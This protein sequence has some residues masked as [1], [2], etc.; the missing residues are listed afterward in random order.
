MTYEEVYKNYLAVNA[1]AS[2]MVISEEER[3]ICVAK[4]RDAL[5]LPPNNA[6]SGLVPAI[7]SD[8]NTSSGTSH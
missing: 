6:C 3:Q 1:L 5:G 8:K 7:G 2:N 4:L